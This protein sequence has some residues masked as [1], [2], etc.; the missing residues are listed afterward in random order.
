MRKALF[1]LITTDAIVASL[2]PPEQWYERSAVPDTPP[3][4]FA[5]LA[6]TGRAR[7]GKGLRSQSIQVWVYQE[8]GSYDL[9]EKVLNRVEVILEEVADFKYLGERIAA[10]TPRGINADL[11]DDAWRANTG[12]LD[13]VVVGGYV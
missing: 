9:I 8:R 12:S 7:V 1:R 4:P 3:K 5:V 10:A 2:I 13:A 6:F 11:Y